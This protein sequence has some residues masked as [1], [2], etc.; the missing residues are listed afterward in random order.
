VSLESTTTV[1]TRR[2]TLTG[3]FGCVSAFVLSPRRSRHPFLLWASAALLLPSVTSYLTL[4]LHS[5]SKTKKKVSS[6]GKDKKQDLE[7]SRFGDAVYVDTDEGETSEEDING[8]EVG[9]D[10]DSW[11]RRML[12]QASGSG[13]AFSVMVLGLWGDRA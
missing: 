12:I 8:E 2:L 9:R 5:P 7:K 11:S 4:S 10:I 3:L 13:V 1:L 6:K